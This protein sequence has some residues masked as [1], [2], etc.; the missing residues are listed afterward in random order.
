VVSISNLCPLIIT[1]KKDPSIA[2]PKDHSAI[3]EIHFLKRFECRSAV[4]HTEIKKP[5][6]KYILAAVHDRQHHQQQLELTRVV[7]H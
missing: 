6:A 1:T 3:Q 7:I 4:V 5:R 2:P